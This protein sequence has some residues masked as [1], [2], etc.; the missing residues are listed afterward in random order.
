MID[1]HLGAVTCCP[2]NLG[3]GLRGSVLIKVPKLADKGEKHLLEICEKF[4]L[5]PR[6][7]YGEHSTTVGGIHDISNKYRLG[8]SEVALVQMMIDG[9]NEVI[10][11]EK[12]A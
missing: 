7:L 4:G 12:A 11:L 1:P 8:H 6:G 10:K 5:Q 9:V 2:S 3:T